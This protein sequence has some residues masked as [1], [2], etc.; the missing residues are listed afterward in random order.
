RTHN[1][2][3]HV[4]YVVQDDIV[5]GNLTVKENLMFSA[6]VRLSTEYSTIEKSKIVDDVIVQLGLEKCADTSRWH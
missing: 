5:C 3:S 1:Y 4:G 2:K 6:N